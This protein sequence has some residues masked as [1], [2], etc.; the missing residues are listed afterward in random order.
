[1]R[2]V[3]DNKSISTAARSSHRSTSSRYL[4]SKHVNTARGVTRLLIDYGIGFLVMN[5][6]AVRVVMAGLQSLEGSCRGSVYDFRHVIISDE[7]LHRAS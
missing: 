2:L 6:K 5:L 1:M 7:W 4:F 3:C